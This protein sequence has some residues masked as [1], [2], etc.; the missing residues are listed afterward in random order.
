MGASHSA[1]SEDILTSHENLGSVHNFKEIQRHANT[2]KTNG[3]K[4]S[5]LDKQTY[6]HL[7]KNTLAKLEREMKNKERT[8]LGLVKMKNTVNENRSRR[9]VVGNEK[10]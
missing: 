9:K 8:I 1:L 4:I 2:I 3:L 10:N 6:N 5:N 7:K